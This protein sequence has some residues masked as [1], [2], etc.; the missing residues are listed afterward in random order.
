MRRLSLVLLIGF[1][2]LEGLYG[3]M[4]HLQ[5]LRQEARLFLHDVVIA[6]LVYLIVVWWL[7]RCLA[8]TASSTTRWM[9][10]GI[11]MGGVVFRLTLVGLTPTLS[12]DI[13]RYLWDGRVQLAGIDPYRYAPNDAALAWLRTDEWQRLNHPDIPTV[14]PPL[15]QGAFRLAAWLSP[16]VLM[17]K[18]V[19]VICDLLLVGVL[20][21]LLVRWGISPLMSLIYAWHPLVVIEVAGS[22]HNDVLG[23]LCLVVGLSL[24][25]Q[26]RRAVGTMVLALGFLAKFV[27]VLLW[28]FYL[29]KARR[30]LIVFVAVVVL[31]GWSC[32]SSPHFTPGLWH[33]ARP[34]E[35]NSFLYSV[36][37]AVLHDPF[38]VRLLGG[39]I[40]LGAGFVLARRT[41]DLVAYTVTL[42]Q[43]SLVFAPVVEPWYLLWVIPLWC[44]RFSWIWVIWSGLTMLSYVVLVRFVQDGIWELPVWVKWIEY[45]PLAAFSL[46]R[47]VRGRHRAPSPAASGP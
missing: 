37:L 2:G 10:V 1:L 27:T 18:A 36:L 26:H 11:V 7:R 23:A 45:G 4:A 28:P 33:Y 44:V 31:G 14:Y 41:D 25:H 13:Y 5:D 9:I 40:V 24:W 43:L 42:L 12:D 20:P 46:M 21:F 17:Q 30:L 38:L 34:W 3:H 19:F 39:L 22:G 29:I 32:V 15:M 47:W 35:F 6:L 8:H 16:T